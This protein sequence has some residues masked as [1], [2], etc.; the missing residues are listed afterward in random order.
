[1]NRNPEWGFDAHVTKSAVQIA[2][3]ALATHAIVRHESSQ[4][5]HVQ[6]Q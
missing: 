1:M 5:L 3:L 4:L 6:S 2:T